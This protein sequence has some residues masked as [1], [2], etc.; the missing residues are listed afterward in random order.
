MN[1]RSQRSGAGG[2][3]S[4]GVQVQMRCSV[5]N[6]SSV[7]STYQPQRITALPAY[8]TYRHNFFVSTVYSVIGVL[9]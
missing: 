6:V 2:A 1:E 8:R 7:S 3:G 5:R 4:A 9:K